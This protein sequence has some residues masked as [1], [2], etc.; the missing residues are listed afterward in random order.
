MAM[1]F[2]DVGSYIPALASLAIC[3]IA[4]ISHKYFRARDNL[5]KQKAQSDVPPGAVPL[6]EFLDSLH[7]TLQ[8]RPEISKTHAVDPEFSSSP[9]AQLLIAQSTSFLKTH[10][11]EPDEIAEEMGRESARKHAK[12]RN[13]RRW[14]TGQ[15]TEL[16]L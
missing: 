5:N 1:L 8:T 13:R 15:F 4:F 9:S 3:A 16:N 2:T 7:N 12:Q 6:R 14:S 10:G 11:V